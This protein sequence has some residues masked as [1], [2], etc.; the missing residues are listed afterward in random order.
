MQTLQSLISPSLFLI[1]SRY[2][3]IIP[4]KVRNTRYQHPTICLLLCSENS[5]TWTITL[6]SNREK[7]FLLRRDAWGQT[8][9]LS[10]FKWRRGH[11]LTEKI[12]RMPT[13]PLAR[14]MCFVAGKSSLFIRGD[15][16]E[17][18]CHIATKVLCCIISLIKTF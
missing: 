18:C 2:I 6:K 14:I 13:T 16:R 1:H 7:I 4:Q 11:C 15:R 17:R 10:F 5:C 12:K 9:T 8:Y 3:K